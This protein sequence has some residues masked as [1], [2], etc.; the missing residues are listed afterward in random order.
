M[1]EESNQVA[2]FV[3]GEEG[4]ETVLDRGTGRVKVSDREQEEGQRGGD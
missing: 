1:E 3:R 4:D 2:S